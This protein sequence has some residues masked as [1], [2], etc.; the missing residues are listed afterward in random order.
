MLSERNATFA[1]LM[2]RGMRPGGRLSLDPSTSE[3][4]APQTGKS[5]L[6]YLPYAGVMVPVWDGF[7]WVLWRLPDA[8]LSIN[9]AGLAVGAYEIFLNWNSGNPSLVASAWTSGISRGVGAPIVLK[10]GWY[11]STNNPKWLSLGSVYLNAIGST[12]VSPNYIFLSNRY[13]QLPL[14]IL[15][16]L[17]TDSWLPNQGTTEM[18]GNRVG[19]TS[20]GS[21]SRTY[22]MNCTASALTDIAFTGILICNTKGAGTLAIALDSDTVLSTK[23]TQ[24]YADLNGQ[25]LTM[26][27]NFRSTCDLG[28]HYIQAMQVSYSNTPPPTFTSNGIA[29]FVGYHMA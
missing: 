21:F 19:N 10:H 1:A 3:P 13:N 18:W 20:I 14:P 4:I 11:V 5:V 9:L 29:A 22:V 25:S 24:A 26:S 28:L 16:T 12:E 15:R 23:A 2:D 8:G 27:C 6:Y 17:Q 7:R